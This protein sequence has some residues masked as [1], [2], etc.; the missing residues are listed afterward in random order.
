MLLNT[1]QKRNHDGNLNWTITN[2]IYHH[3]CVTVNGV[4]GR[5]Y[6]ERYIYIYNTKEEKRI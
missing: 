5:E 3:L 4:L 2:I 1:G 6:E